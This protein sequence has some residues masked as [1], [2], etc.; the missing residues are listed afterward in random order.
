M[1]FDR[2]FAL[3]RA[4]PTVKRNEPEPETPEQQFRINLRRAENDVHTA[5]AKVATMASERDPRRWDD[6]KT[7]ASQAIVMA[8]KAMVAARS[9]EAATPDGAVQIAEVTR[10]LDDAKQQLAAAGPRPD[11][12]ARVALED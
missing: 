10:A 1:S 5:I 3:G 8:E 7:S 2:E 4:P 11:G 12:I 9:R 6:A